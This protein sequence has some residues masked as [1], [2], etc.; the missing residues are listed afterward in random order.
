VKGLGQSWDSVELYLRQILAFIGIDDVQ[1]VRTEGM[2]YRRLR[3]Q[4]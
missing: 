1:T 2:T 4:W 3:T